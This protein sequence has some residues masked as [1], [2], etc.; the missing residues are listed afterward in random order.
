M[1]TSPEKIRADDEEA[2]KDLT[3]H[4]IAASFSQERTS[5]VAGKCTVIHQPKGN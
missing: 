1:S 4:I 3:C 2:M 5:F